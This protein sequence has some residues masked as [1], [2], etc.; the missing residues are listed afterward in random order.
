MAISAKTRKTLW[1]KSGNRCLVCRIEVVQEVTE[2]ENLVVGEEC[3]IISSKPKGPR[4]GEGLIGGYDDYENLLILCANDHKRIDELTQIYT[5]NK[6]RQM[7][8]I[9]ENWVRTT[10]EKD[11]SAFT[12]DQLNIR[13]L[14]LL[15]SGQDLIQAITDVH[16]YEF[17]TSEIKT[18]SEAHEIGGFFEELKSFGDMLAEMTIP[19]ITEYRIY[20]DEEVRKLRD[21]GFLL[22]GLK[23]KVRLFN[24]GQD[25]GPFQSSVVVVVRADNPSIVGR[26]LIAKFENL[27]HKNPHQQS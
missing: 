5:P 21:S 14:P 12:N 4:H 6:L 13:S 26:F 9:H 15:D 25:L 1:S 23:R 11:A 3:H 7:K 20:L 18:N 10:L 24:L 22:F 17:D 27:N 8:R 2:S 16:A 19:Q